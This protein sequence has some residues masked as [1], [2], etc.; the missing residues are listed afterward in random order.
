MQLISYLDTLKPRKKS[1]KIDVPVAIVFTKTDLCDEWIR[2]PGAFAR[3][4]VAELYGQCQ[5]R[6]ARFSFYFSGVAGSTGR[7]VD[8]SGQEMLIPLRIEPRG[9]VEPFAWMVKTLG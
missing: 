3:A 9:V 5:A 8:R 7:L 2:D 4:N 6:L 1:R